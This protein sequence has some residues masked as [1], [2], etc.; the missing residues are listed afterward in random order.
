M[1]DSKAKTF[2]SVVHNVVKEEDEEL[3]R[4]LAQD[5]DAKPEKV[6]GDDTGHLPYTI[7][8]KIKSMNLY[9]IFIKCDN[10]GGRRRA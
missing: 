4:L 6:P 2:L 7:F 1:A 10:K 3:N 8:R 9:L 5:V